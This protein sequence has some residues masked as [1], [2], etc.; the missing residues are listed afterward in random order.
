MFFLVTT[1][2]EKF[3]PKKNLQKLKNRRMLEASQRKTVHGWR[4]IWSIDSTFCRLALAQRK[5]FTDGVSLKALIRPFVG[6]H[7]HLYH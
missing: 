6:W 5:Q 7:W 1:T 4:F 3:R 2:F